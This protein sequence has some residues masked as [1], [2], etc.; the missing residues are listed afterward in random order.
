MLFCCCRHTIIS[1]ILGVIFIGKK[2][3]KRYHGI[4]GDGAHSTHCVRDDASQ[5]TLA[6]RCV[7]DD[8]KKE[9][10]CHGQRWRVGS[11]AY[12]VV[13]WKCKS[14]RVPLLAVV[15][16]AYLCVQIRRVKIDVFCCLVVRAETKSRIDGWNCN[17]EA[18]AKNGEYD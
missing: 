16:G 14:C 6:H 13:C 17:I 10:Y 5:S 1:S 15:F 4:K 2:R 9:V 12:F 7:A 11:L 18:A 3:D 8:V